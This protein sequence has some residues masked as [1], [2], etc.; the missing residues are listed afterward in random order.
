MMRVILR[1]H[2]QLGLSVIPRSTRAEGQ[3]ENLDLYGWELLPE[4]MEA[5][6]TLDEGSRCGPDPMTFG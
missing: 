6:A 2:V 4:E 3:A 1:W 5:I